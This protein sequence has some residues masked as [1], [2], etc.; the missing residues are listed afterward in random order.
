MKLILI[1]TLISSTAFA[2]AARWKT[3][4]KTQCAKHLISDDPYQYEETPV[5]LLIN[6]VK[7]HRDQIAWAEMDVR[8]KDPKTPYEE[9]LQI[10]NFFSWMAMGE[11]K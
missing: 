6:L 7:V 5:H 8:L 2:N 1:L 4:L 10:E 3:F 9:K 11:R